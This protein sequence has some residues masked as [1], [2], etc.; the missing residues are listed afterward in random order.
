MRCGIR[1][2]AR[3]EVY[4]YVVAYSLSPN[5]SKFT[6]GMKAMRT[7]SSLGEGGSSR[8]FR[9]FRKISRSLLRELH[10]LEFSDELTKD[11]R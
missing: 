7:L 8:G 1:S 4:R 2:A 11:L 3:A 9:E 5:T 6:T 10:W